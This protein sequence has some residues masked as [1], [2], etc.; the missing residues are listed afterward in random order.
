MVWRTNRLQG[1]LTGSVNTTENRLLQQLILSHHRHYHS[2]FSITYCMVCSISVF[3]LFMQYKSVFLLLFFTIPTVLY[4]TS[5]PYGSPMQFGIWSSFTVKIIICLPPHYLYIFL[6]CQLIAVTVT[7]MEVC[8][9][10]QEI[11]LGFEFIH[12][13]TWNV[14]LSH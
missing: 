3:D 9:I 12:K 13:C 4:V 11:E 10:H 14:K 8:I 5:Q 6:Y 7:K 1:T 2:H